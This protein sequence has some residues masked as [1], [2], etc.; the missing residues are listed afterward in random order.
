MSEVRQK[1]GLYNS[2]VSRRQPQ[3]GCLLYGE[4]QLGITIQQLLAL[5]RFC[6][7]SD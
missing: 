7:S 2:Q 6:L 3:A 5:A 1:P 4:I